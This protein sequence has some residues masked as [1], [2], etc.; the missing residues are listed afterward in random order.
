M[1]SS[2]ATI[3]NAQHNL[4]K[5]L[6]DLNKKLQIKVPLTNTLMESC[7]S[8]LVPNAIIAHPVDVKYSNSTIQDLMFETLLEV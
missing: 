1:K 7:F 2:K 8:Y 3:Q 5:F 6:D 4:R